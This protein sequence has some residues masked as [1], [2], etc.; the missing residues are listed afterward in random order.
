MGGGNIGGAV[1][2]ISGASSGLGRALAIGLA[3][4]GAMLSLFARDIGRLQRTADECEQKSQGNNKP[5]ITTGD[6]RRAGDCK[7]WITAAAAHFGRLDYLVNNAAISM[8]MPVGEV[9][10][11]GNFRPVMDTGFW[12]AVQ[13]AHAA[14]PHLRASCGMIVNISSVQGKTAI[15]YHSVYAASKHALEGFFMSLVMEETNIRLLTVRPGWID[16]TRINQNRIGNNGNNSDN[17]S[18]DNINHSREGVPVEYCA[19]Q[20]IKAIESRVEVLTIP[21]KYRWLPVLA[22][23]FPATIRKAV[24]KKTNKRYADS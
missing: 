23:L 14:L 1:F 20:I 3:E 2:A 4:R 16:G 9:E 15:P 18:G 24:R 12:G 13:C 6:I 17:E 21:A 5:H 11:I 8:R 10:D 7:Q 22:E 19:R